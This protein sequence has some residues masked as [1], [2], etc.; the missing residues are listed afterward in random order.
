MK[1]AAAELLRTLPP[2][3]PET[4][5]PEIAGSVRR[6]G[7]KIVVLDDDPTGT[8]T[9]YGV[10]VF[11]EWSLEFLTE[12]LADSGQIG[13]V[14]TN[15]RSLSGE[16]ARELSRAIARNLVAASEATSREFVV[17]SRGDSTLRGHYPDEVCSFTHELG[18]AFDGVLIIPFFQ[19]GGRLTVQDIHYV[20]DGELLIPAAETEYARD[21][22]FGY[23][24]SDLR[25]WVSEK[26]GYRISPQDVASISIE[27]ERLGGPETVA[28]RLEA[29]V[30]GQVCV[31]NAASYRD[32]EVFVAGLLRAEAGGK[33]FFYRTA[34][35]FVRVRGGLDARAPLTAQELKAHHRKSTAGRTAGLVIAGSH[36]QR[37]SAQIAA[38]LSMPEVCCLEMCV[39][40]LLSDNG[41]R[42]EIARVAAN[43]NRALQSGQD[44]MIFTSRRVAAGSSAADA[45]RIASV[46][47]ASLVSVVESITERPAWLI[48]KGG[49]TSSDIATKALGIRRAQVLGQAFPGV[50]VWLT[51]EDSRWPELLYVVFPGNVGQADTLAG[52][53][54]MLRS[55]NGE[56]AC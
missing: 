24:N 20:R 35:S 21:K 41:S 11:T 22:T 13:Y 34:A 27:E 8:Q 53:I 4:L 29:M 51:N 33:R 31:V 46:V 37:S 45:L 54:R 18:Q 32:L 44:T 50:P 9:V 47:S 6:S 7:Q 55:G 40:D 26:H 1:V 19:E 17:I 5:L 16:K 25:N 30:R 28:R 2:E 52:M 49:I 42:R 14:L 3:W 48:A 23:E 38:V 15:S 10:P 36:V 39:E 43:A 56:L 12:L